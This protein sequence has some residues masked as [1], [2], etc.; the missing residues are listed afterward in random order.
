LPSALETYKKKTKKSGLLFAK[1]KKFHVNGV[2]HNIRFFDPYPFVTKSAKGKYI[3]DVDGNKY[4]D[5]WMGHWSLILGHAFP[6]IASVVKKQLPSCWMHGTVNEMA[7]SFSEIIQ[8]AVPVAEK[9]RYASTGTEATMYA[10]RIARSATGK[11]IIAKIVGGWHGYTSDLLKSV[12]Y[13][14]NETES[15]GLVDE[16]HIVSIPYN[17]LEKSLEILNSVKND[18]A[19]VII[20]PVLG[21]G[22]CIPAT[23]EYLLG[24]QEFVHKNNALFLLDEIV[25]GFRFSFGCYYKKMNLDP[26]IV[27]LGKIV[28]GGFP[29]GVICGKEEIMQ[30]S[31]TSSHKKLDRSYIGGGTFSANP[32]TMTSGRAMLSFLKK[33]S[34]V[35]SKIGNLGRQARKKL[36]KIFDGKV[37]TTGMGSLFMTHFLSNGITQIKNASD[38]AMCD[39][40]MLHKYHFEMIAKDDIFFLP[41]KLGAFSYSHS[42]SDVKEL[43][44]ASNRFSASI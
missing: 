14:F 29:I 2:S 43:L 42:Q 35:Y 28:G 5:Y 36:D 9:I 7:I 44:D 17:D 20:E 11:K 30:T 19:G 10:V 21:G 12:N 3:Y 15:A 34:S 39:I 38:A 25:T 27:T 16:E 40:D 18:L 23:K 26:D 37:I 6:A 33:N 4:T 31:N 1:S 8:K 41:G 24:I 22:G 32:I 13:P